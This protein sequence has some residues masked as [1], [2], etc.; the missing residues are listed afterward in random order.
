MIH[1]VFLSICFFAVSVQ[2]GSKFIPIHVKVFLYTVHI[3]PMLSH[4]RSE[5]LLL[6]SNSMIKSSSPVVPKN[7]IGS[8]SRTV[9][10]DFCSMLTQKF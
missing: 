8:V 3:V 10:I 5:C 4:V 6:A 1:T 2:I 7:G 9:S